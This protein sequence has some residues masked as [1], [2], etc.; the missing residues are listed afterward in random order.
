MAARVIG[1]YG[2]PFEVFRGFTQVYPV[3]PKISNVVVYAVIRNWL[4]IMV[5]EALGT[6]VFDQ[7]VQ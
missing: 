7:S 5:E 4:M 6:E 2:D 1:Y 3:L